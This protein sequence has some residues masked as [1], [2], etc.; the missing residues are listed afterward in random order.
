MDEEP[1]KGDRVQ[2]A[3]IRTTRKD[4]PAGDLREIFLAHH[5]QVYRAAWRITGNAGDAEDVLQTVFLKLLRKD[6]RTLDPQGLAAYLRIAAVNTAL[7]LLRSRRAARSAGLRPAEP[8]EIEVPSGAPG[9]EAEQR[10]RELREALRLS[11]ASLG[12]TAAR[13]VALRFL[14]GYDNREIA[15]LLGQTRASVAVTLHRARRKIQNDL[16]PLWAGERQ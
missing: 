8:E 2:Q 13:I 5:R 11:M 1:R 14:E 4:H 9:P 3:A 16:G 10:E 12:P 6:A 15:R 7:D